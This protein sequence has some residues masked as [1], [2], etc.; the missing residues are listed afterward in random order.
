[1]K[2]KIA[3]IMGS[4]SDFSIMEKTTNMLDEFEIPYSVNILSAHR[5]PNELDDHIN[6]IN[7]CDDCKVIIAGAGM[8]A[9]LSGH[10]ASKT[11]KP[12]IGVPLSGSNLD[13]IDALLSTLQMPPGIPVLGVGIDAAKNA[14]LAAASIV[15][16]TDSDLSCLLKSFRHKQAVDVL[17]ADEKLNDTTIERIT[18]INLKYKCHF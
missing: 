7:A 1:M 4:Q 8:S 10:I 9:A 16:L 18:P 11:I 17:L 13:G 15:A 3:I 12:V 6:S 5:T 14:A 2:P